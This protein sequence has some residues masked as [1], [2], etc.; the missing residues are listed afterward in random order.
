[1]IELCAV[2]GY[3]EVGKNMTAI[4][5]DGRVVILDMGLNMNRFIEQQGKEDVYGM[6]ARQLIRTD[7]IPDDGAI[8][9]WWKSVDAIVPTHAHLDHIGAVP[10]L[11]DKYGAPII[12]T[13]FTIEVIKSQMEDNHV[14]LSNEL[15]VLHPNSMFPI[16]DSLKIEF[17]H[18]THSTPQAVMV[19]IHTKEGIILYTNDFK[20]DS[21]PALGKKPNF[22]RLKELGAKGKVI[23]LIVDS[24]RAHENR[25]T[26]SEEVARALLQDVLLGTENEGKAVVVTT[27]SSHLAR[28]KSIL[29]LGKQTGR[30]VVFF[31]RSMERYISAGERVGIVSFTKEAR[32]IKYKRQVEQF[33]REV[34]ERGTRGKYLFVVT[35]HQGEPDAVLSRMAN[36]ETDFEFKRDDHVV[37]SCT[38]I[39]VKI[40]IE[41]RKA[42][43]KTLRKRRVRIF[44]DLHVS[45]HAAREDIRDLITM[46]KPGVVI[47]AHGPKEFRENVMDLCLE[48]G[49][50]RRDV[51]MV[52]NGRRVSLSRK[53]PQIL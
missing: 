26:P 11:A 50:Q 38:V 1:M 22:K 5:V 36:S 41:N 20:F 24:T 19:A 23:A 48:M 33:L 29:D 17:I 45:G 46:T 30:K 25:K 47:P 49:Y 31:G 39:P 12:A 27:F 8:R 6:S 51:L 13:P 35:G 37:F 21:Y 15:K 4:N 14:K 28:L 18:A 53:G 52:E 3:N 43:E 16:N 2:G 32:V 10:F 44:T 42:L 34:Q 7:C 9:Q 40:N